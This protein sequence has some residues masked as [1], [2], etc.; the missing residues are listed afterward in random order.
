[1]KV[2]NRRYSYG[3]RSRGRQRETYIDSLNA[4]A[5]SKAVKNNQSMGTSYDRDRWIAMVVNAC[6]RHDT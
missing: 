1:M 2:K 5:T 6:S 3:Q 4:W